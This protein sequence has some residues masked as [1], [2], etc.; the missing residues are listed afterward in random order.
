MY[1]IIE[2]NEKSDAYLKEKN[3]SDQTI[4]AEYLSKPFDEIITEVNLTEFSI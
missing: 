3:Y 2:T 4:I 1:Y